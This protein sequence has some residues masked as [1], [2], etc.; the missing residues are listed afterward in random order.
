MKIFDFKNLDKF[1]HLFEKKNIRF[2][3]NG[4]SANVSVK[5]YKNYYYLIFSVNHQLCLLSKFNKF[6]D[7]EKQI[8][9]NLKLLFCSK[10]NLFDKEGNIERHQ[11][12]V[13]IK[14]KNYLLTGLADDYGGKY[15][16]GLFLLNFDFENENIVGKPIKICDGKRMDT[17]N[18]II[19][20]K[21]KIYLFTR[22]NIPPEWKSGK[23]HLKVFNTDKNN[24]EI[25][26]KN[27]IV[28]NFKYFIYSTHHFIIND[29]IFAYIFCYDKKS[30]NDLYNK[31]KIILSKTNNFKDYEII[32]DDYFPDDR[33]IVP[34]IG[35]IEDNKKY[36]TLF[37][38]MGKYLFLHE[39]EINKYI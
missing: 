9:Q 28:I 11:C 18:H 8:N 16:K 27:N 34:G 37:T 29:I 22:Y 15:E 31:S 24:E 35:I 23:R 1:R 4:I 17:I 14:N 30:I 39:F 20:H 13:T 21:N 25:Y 6:L 19:E 36:Y 3:K 33:N 7:I 2:L 12:I 32:V 10:S 26:F 5:K 38:K